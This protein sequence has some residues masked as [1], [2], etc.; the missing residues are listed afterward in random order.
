MVRKVNK[1]SLD[2]R[3]HPGL[4]VR[5]VLGDWMV[6]PVKLEHL[7]L[8][9][10]LD[11]LDQRVRRVKVGIQEHKE[12]LEVLVFLVLLDSLVQQDR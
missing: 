6:H 4:M 5:Q 2:H 7:D 8:K 9:D 11:H 1:D 12:T 3:E 10:L